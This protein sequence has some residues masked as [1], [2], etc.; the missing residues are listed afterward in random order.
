MPQGAPLAVI[1]IGS[2]SGRLLVLRLAESGHLEVVNDA[3]APLQLVRQLTEEG[4]LSET[5]LDRTVSAVN[6]FRLA[7]EYSG[8]KKVIAVA[9]SAVREA[10]NREEFV[11]E[12]SRQTKVKLQVLSGD[13]EAMA[14]ARGA[15]WGI[16]ADQGLVIDIGGGSVEVAHFEKRK[17]KDLWT[18]P[19][20]ALRIT[21]RFLTSDPP[22]TGEITALREHVKQSLRQSGIG[23]L[24][25]DEV[26]VGTGGA[27]RNIAK[28]DRA[29]DLSPIPRLHGHVLAQIRVAD[30][31]DRLASLPAARR[32]GISGLSSDRVD[33]I[34]GG[35][36]TLY[37]A[38]EHS[39]ANQL[40]VSGLGLREGVA[41]EHFA[42]EA[43]PAE[44]RRASA[45][46]LA[47]RFRTWRPDRAEWRGA[48]TTTLIDLLEPDCPADLK[49]LCVYAALLLDIG[50][51]VDYYSK[52]E[53]A[54]S[55]T[56]AADLHGFSHRSLAQLCGLIATAEAGHVPLGLDAIL[57]NKEMAVVSRLSL[58]LTIADEF[59]RRSHP[60]DDLPI[61]RRDEDEAIVLLAPLA[62]PWTG[63]EVAGRFRRSFGRS[64]RLETEARGAEAAVA[65]KFK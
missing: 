28:I 5:A 58:I 25:S 37:C 61:S 42:M 21:D 17:P 44:V 54:A 33:S 18:L 40:L 7:A 53:H 50:E 8:A 46:A 9:T 39:R 14:A 6:S 56:L 3:V 10:G 48:I 4:N 47:Q 65:V 45:L 64:L 60:G 22:K 24:G 15:I 12:V 26:M 35:V 16:P 31:A 36:N 32:S 52:W 2:N 55:V 51:S 13:E 11:A 30:I 1:D 62:H 63:S 49:E 59:E 38:M 57:S 43:K 20:G 23:R 29:D 41:L 34:V 19:L 27:I